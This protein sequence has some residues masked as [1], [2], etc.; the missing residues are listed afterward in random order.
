MAENANGYPSQVRAPDLHYSY[1]LRHGDWE[2]FSHH[3]AVSNKS[4]RIGLLCEGA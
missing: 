4:H 2:L 3:M 1:N